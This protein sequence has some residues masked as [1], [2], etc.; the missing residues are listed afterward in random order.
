MNSILYSVTLLNAMQNGPM[1]DSVINPPKHDDGWQI[2]RKP[3]KG[4]QGLITLDLLARRQQSQYRSMRW[5][6]LV[7]NL[8]TGFTLVFRLLSKVLVRSQ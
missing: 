6:N 3:T 5:L 2:E 1:N 7:G 4:V 8:Y